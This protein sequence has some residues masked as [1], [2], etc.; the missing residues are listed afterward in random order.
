MLL[1]RPNLYSV[2]N[3]KYVPLYIPPRC[4]LVRKERSARLMSVFSSDLKAD[5]SIQSGAV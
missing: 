1:K 3:E 2:I 4:A 5:F